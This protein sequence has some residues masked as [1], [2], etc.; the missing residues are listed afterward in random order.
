MVEWQGYIDDKHGKH[1]GLRRDSCRHIARELCEPR[2]S[3]RGGS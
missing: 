2:Q 1:G 3:S